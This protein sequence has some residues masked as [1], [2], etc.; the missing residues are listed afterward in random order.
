MQVPA[1]R[2]ALAA[3]SE[4]LPQVSF[5]CG[6]GF[7]GTCHVRVLDGAVEHRGR[8]ADDHMAICVSR[9]PEHMV[10]DL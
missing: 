6:R 2:S 7:C 4:V 10:L 1:D 9:A 3:I 8:P 5:S